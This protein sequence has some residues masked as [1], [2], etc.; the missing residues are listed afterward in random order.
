[1]AGAADI[2]A[3]VAVIAAVIVAGIVDL[4]NIL[5]GLPAI[6]ASFAVMLAGVAV[7]LANGC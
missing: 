6:V 1:M 3:G 4:S 5:P 2:M 7:G